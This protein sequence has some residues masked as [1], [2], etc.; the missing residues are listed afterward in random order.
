LLDESAP[1]GDPQTADA[2]IFYSISNCQRGLAGISFGDFL[3][4]RVVDALAI[5]LSRVKIFATLSP[6]TGFRAWLEHQGRSAPADLLLPADLN[7]RPA[8]LASVG[9]VT[10]NDE[11]FEAC[12][13]GYPAASPPPAEG[14]PSHPA[15]RS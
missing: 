2:A 12:A 8:A 14:R 5:E 7:G 3:I 6:V 13:A 15:T 4:K 1:I 10:G 11:A 9:I